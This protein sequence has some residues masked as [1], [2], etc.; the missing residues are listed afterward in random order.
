MVRVQKDHLSHEVMHFKEA[1]TEGHQ[2]N[3]TL[4]WPASAVGSLREDANPGLGVFS[5]RWL[6]ILG[7]PSGP[8]NASQTL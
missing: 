1:S 5:H 7:V 6:C 2:N 3:S 4:I 8:K